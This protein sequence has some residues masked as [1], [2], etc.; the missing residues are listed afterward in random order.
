MPAGHTRPGSYIACG[1]SVAGTRHIRDQIPCEDAWAGV[2]LPDALIIAVADGLSSAEYGGKGADIAVSSSVRD[3]T[4]AYKPG[5][6]DIPA[7]IRSAM[8]AG[9]EAIHDH[10]LSEGLHISSF[11]TTLLLAVLTPD[12]AFCGHIGD[13]ACVA[14]SEGEASLLSV[15]GTAEYA[16]ETAVLTAQT[17]ESHCRISHRAADAI[18]C[19]TDGC[20]GALIRREDGA[21]VPY[22]PFVVPLVR[23]LGE[24]LDEGRDLN[25]EIADLLSSSRMRALSSDD[26]TLAVGFS[27]SGEPF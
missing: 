8:S 23:S 22:S 15:P 9:R 18:I 10:A 14:L 11:A 5:E 2:I 19:A 7:L 25:S 3:A 6:Q 1:A 24:Y 4:D 27:L 12:G 26:M 20:Q 13:G 17:W 21:Y 16:N